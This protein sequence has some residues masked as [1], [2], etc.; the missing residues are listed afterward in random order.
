M[1]E[2]EVTK[3]YTE[4]K[5]AR[6]LVSQIKRLKINGYKTDCG[7]DGSDLRNI[8]VRLES[9]RKNLS[10]KFL[11]EG[12]GYELTVSKITKESLLLSKS[13]EKITGKKVRII[14]E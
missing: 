12:K 3:E 1:V 2:I 10:F 14:L 8:Y 4:N 9:F 5:K 13:I 6:Q 11:N 7:Y